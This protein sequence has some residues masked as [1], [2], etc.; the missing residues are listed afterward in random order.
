MMKKLFLLMAF[1]S[2]FVSCKDDVPEV[3]EAPITIMAY[4]VADASGIEDDIWTNIAAMYDG[5]SLIKKSATLLIYWDGSGDY[6]VWSNPVV[7]RYETDG[8]GNINGKKPLLE[9]A[10]VEDVVALAEVVK[11]YPSQLSVNKNVMTQVLKDM[12]SFAP[13]SKVGLIAASHG[14][15]WTNSIYMPRSSTRSFGQDGKG[16]DNTMLIKDMRDAMKSTGT[17]F[18]FL[19]FD[20]CYMGTAEVCYELSDVTNYLI[21]SVMEVPAYGF[22]YEVSMDYLYEGTVD[23]YKNICQAYIDF[24]KQRCEKGNHAWGTI[25][26]VD[27]KEMKALATSV[28]NVFMDEN[29]KNMHF[30]KHFISSEVQEYGRDGGSEIAYDMK[31]V[32]MQL[33]SLLRN[34]DELDL[35]NEQLEK[36]ILYK[37]CLEKA[38]PSRYS[39]NP[40]QYCGLGM[41]VPLYYMDKWNSFFKTIDWYTAA[42]WN[43]V[44]FSWDF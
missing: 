20:A 2:I 16:T 11:E 4:L 33:K 14:S 21:A 35:F 27:S 17:K 23:G 13:T 15:A 28:K 31:G 26:L 40:D 5:F 6:G 22:P 38:D 25:A 39:V 10:S 18:D 44:D 7:L 9:N 34:G 41:Y 30:D 8:K 1:F 37:G 12:I 32:M 3:E 24:Y 43:E 29:M 36:T 42:G 19:L